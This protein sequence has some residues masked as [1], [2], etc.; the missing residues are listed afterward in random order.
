M[1][2]V[3]HGTRDIHPR[4]F[5]QQLFLPYGSRHPWGW[6]CR[7]GTPLFAARARRLERST[8]FV[9]IVAKLVALA[10]R[11][12]GIHVWTAAALDLTTHVPR[13]R[14]AANMRHAARLCTLLLWSVCPEHGTKVQDINYLGVRSSFAVQSSPGCPHSTSREPPALK[15]MTRDSNFVWDAATIST[16]CDDQAISDGC[17]GV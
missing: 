15:S 7:A 12:R 17:A 2:G 11:K 9:A 3:A 4:S 6:A 13:T 16:W 10:M 8:T 14:V 1:R 5:L